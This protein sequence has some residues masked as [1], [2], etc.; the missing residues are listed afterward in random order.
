MCYEILPV[1]Y[2]FSWSYNVILNKFIIIGVDTN[3]L[4]SD[5]SRIEAFVY[6]LANLNPITGILTP[7]TNTGNTYTEYLIRQ[8]T[9]LDQW[10]TIGSV[11]GQS[12]PSLL[13]PTSQQISN[14]YGPYL[15]VD[16]HSFQYSGSLPLSFAS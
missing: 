14:N 5:G 3:Y 11:L 7:A 16:D 8:I 15:V 12:Y 13:D 6:T 9:W 2:R 10:T 4:Q 1:A